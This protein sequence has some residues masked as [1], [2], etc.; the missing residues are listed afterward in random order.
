MVDKSGFLCYNI[1]IMQ[2]KGGS[3]LMNGYRVAAICISRVHEDVLRKFITAFNEKLC[4]NGWRTLVFSTN[5]D[6]FPQSASNR[7]EA[8]IF[9]ILQTAAIDAIVICKDKIL[10]PSCFAFLCRTAESRH[11]PTYIVNGEQE[12]FPDLTFDHPRGFEKVVRHLVEC[13]GIRDFHFL[14]GSKGNPYSEAR[15]DVMAS[16]LQEYGIPFDET[17]ISYGDFWSFPA[18]QATLRLIE[19][20]RLPKAIVCANDTMAL[21]VNSV[22]RQ[23]GYRVPE[24]VIVTGF[25][26]LDDIMFSVPKITSCSCNYSVLGRTTAE[27]VLSGDNRPVHHKITPELLTLESCG[28]CAISDFDTAKYLM[29]LRNSFHRYQNEDD[30]L[31][32]ITSKIQECSSLPEVAAHLHHHLFYNMACVLTEDAADPAIDPMLRR[33]RSSFLKNGLLLSDA[34]HE[35]EPHDPI[36]FPIREILP[37]LGNIFAMKEPVILIALHQMEIPLGYLVF[38]YGEPKRSNYLKVGQI[39]I[40]LGN[41]LGGFRSI[42]YQKHLQE[43][44]RYD[45]LTGLY[46]RSA[47]LRQFSQQQKPA[48]NEPITLVLCDLDGLKYIN[49]HFSHQEGDNAIKTVSE[50]LHTVCKDGLCCRYGGDELV[51]VLWGNVSPEAI[52]SRIHAILDDY[53]RTSAKPYLVSTSIGICC[54]SEDLNS[55]FARADEIM[56]QRKTAKKAQRVE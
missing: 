33:A 16:V 52:R 8:S 51:A 43:T 4:E 49:D 54:G 30:S 22:L 31:S 34:D 45:Q 9:Q 14:A 28:C 53:N 46:T 47:F 48:D 21:A 18:E 35:K 50:A 24:D 1:H 19:E 29:E 32:G 7:G 26:G 2:V 36:P 5:T 10:D 42:Q 3:A 25:D 23:H 44:Y 55:L 56:Y 12:G 38:W 27:L 17:R 15:K 11:I 37:D 6:L 41:A 40:A 13:H 20:K 39:S